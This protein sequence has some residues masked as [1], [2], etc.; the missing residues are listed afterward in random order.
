M[1]KFDELRTVHLEITNRCQASCPMCPRK[2]HGGVEN[3]W[4]KIADWSFEDFVKIFDQETLNQLVTIYFCGNYGDP[5]MHDDL[6][7]MCQYVKDNAPHIDLRIHTNGGARSVAWWKNLRQAMPEKHVVIFGIDGLEDTNHLYRVGVNWKTLIRNAKTFIE[8][9]GTAEW[10]YI[11][12]KHNEHQESEAEQFSKELGFQR[13][14]VKNTTRFIGDD[15]Y[16][17]L[18]KDGNV[19]RYLEP[20][21]NNEVVFITP[22]QIRNYKTVLMNSEINCYVKQNKEVYIDAHKHVF[23]CC[24]LASTPYN[25]R[26]PSLPYNEA[27]HKTVIRHIYDRILEQYYELVESLGGIEN[28]YAIDR[29]IKEIINDE[30]WQTV[31]NSYWN[32]NKLITCARACGDMINNFSKPKDQFIKR[33]IH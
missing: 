17:V 15:K 24:W 29:P 13:F 28:L 4:L 10:V 19:E 33:V 22:D 14:T 31:W 7:R 8:A 12:F 30:R 1:F 11:R 32:E 25:Y 6:I 23:P 18:D 16:S 20:P 3:P 2:F 21:T 26:M 9:G 27:D 5:I